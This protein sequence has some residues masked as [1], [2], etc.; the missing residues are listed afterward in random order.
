[1]NRISFYGNGSESCGSIGTK[2][3]TTR[4]ECA[5]SVGIRE[6]EPEIKLQ[7]L[8]KDTVCFRG[9]EDT[10]P[11]T[12]KSS[13]WKKVLYFAGACAI[14]VG[15]LGSA[16]KWKT[17]GSSNKYVTEYFNKYAAEP[18]YNFCAGAKDYAVKGYNSVKNWFSSGKK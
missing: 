14:V 17:K 12:H 8:D 5:G 3:E 1:M 4:Q 9:Q 11:Q 13:F 7:T 2:I 16:Y 18:C 6:Q 10:A 15:G